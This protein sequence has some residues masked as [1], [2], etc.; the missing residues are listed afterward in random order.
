MAL[1]PPP[2]WDDPEAKKQKKFNK[3]MRNAII[4]LGVGIGMMLV[5]PFFIGTEEG[6]SSE[7]TIRLFNTLGFSM[8]G[9]GLI[10]V[11][12]GIFL[13]KQMTKIN[14]V[15]LYLVLPGI[16]LKALMDWQG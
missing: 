12:C 3:A 7:S 6:V 5:K 1:I 8:I 10:I 9:Y 14:L 11:A 4:I 15:A 2:P 16:I 13:R